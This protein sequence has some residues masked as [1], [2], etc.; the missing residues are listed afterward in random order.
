MTLIAPNISHKNHDTTYCLACRRRDVIPPSSSCANAMGPEETWGLIM[1]LVTTLVRELEWHR[2]AEVQ[3]GL[4]EI[5][6]RVTDRTDLEMVVPEL[7]HMLGEDSKA[8]KALKMV[9]SFTA[10]DM[11]VFFFSSQ[12]G[13]KDVL[14]RV[15]GGIS[16]FEGDVHYFPQEISS[17]A[18]F[19]PNVRPTHHR[20][21][22][23][24]HFCSRLSENHR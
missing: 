15:R 2:L 21:T 13:E 24:L 5:A 9:S 16:R 18:G 20:C 14:L 10:I 6:R 4:F 7:I 12:A 17:F 22:P 11:G 19:S 1:N 3:Q 23:R 8:L